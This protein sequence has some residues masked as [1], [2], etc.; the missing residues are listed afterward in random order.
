MLAALGLL[1]ACSKMPVAIVNANELC[2]D[3]QH[4]TVSKEDKL[5]QETAS[6][7]EASNG[8]RVNWGCA[9]KENRAG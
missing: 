3:W 8:S 7:L 2:R 4:Q 1:S 5:T 6:N 9:P